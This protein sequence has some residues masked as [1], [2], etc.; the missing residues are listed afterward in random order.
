MNRLYLTIACCLFFMPLWGQLK[1][2]TDSVYRINEITVSSNRIE[3]YS[4]GNKIK[5][6]DS[7]LVGS[8]SA[9]S[10]AQVLGSFSQVQM[11]SYGLGLCNSSIR[12]AGSGHTAVIW[13]GFNL[14]DLLNGGADF[15]LIPINFI[16]DIKIQYGGG[17]AL[18][19]SGAIG[20]VVHLNNIINFDKGFSSS[21]KTG[22]GSY[23]NT[24]GGINISYSDEKY[25]VFVKSFYNKAKNNFT[26][27]N[28]QEVNA[29]VQSLKNA[30][31]EQYGLL[32]GNAFKLGRQSKI[33]S[34]FWFQ[35]NDKNIPPTMLTY[36]NPKKDNQKDVFYRATVSW[37]TWKKN[38]NFVLRSGF[39]NYFLVYDTSDYRSI[40][41][42]AEA[43]YNLKISRNHLVNTGIDYTYEKGISENLIS[44]AQR[45]RISL[46]ISYKFT[47]KENQ[48][49]IVT[50]FRNEIIDHT[51]TPFTFSLG[52]ERPLSNWI[53]LKG[54][55]SKN[56]RVP[57]FN[58]LYW[59][60]LGNP[61]LKCE[62]GFN[63]DVGTLLYK[64]F[65]KI[66]IRNE[67]TVFNNIVS[68]WILWYPHNDTKWRPENISLVRSRGLEND[69]SL[70]I[71]IG[72]ISSKT[73]ISYSFTRSIKMKADFANDPGLH[74][75]LI[76]VPLHK[77]LFAI[78]M[79]YNG[80]SLYYGQ[81]YTGIRYSETDNSRHINPYSIG[82]V[83]ISKKFHYRDKM[84]NISFQVN[85]LWNA[86]YQVMPYYPMPL[87]NYMLNVQLNIK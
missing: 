19:G 18:F 5:N 23:D 28:T 31:R 56:Y 33:E 14:Q 24:Y 36:H 71:P 43:E 53:L 67:V 16:D 73:S 35:D 66:D 78:T 11:N 45:N 34:F 87:R 32:A 64:K 72:A 25:A 30:E 21:L 4:V 2:I 59:I 10:L 75:Q 57:T 85:N 74:K 52:I 61:D 50:N 70:V 37:K 40:Q 76:Y 49:K 55:L 83:S 7:A 65:G 41:S 17:S 8:Y 22:Y 77:G 29:P 27:R 39:S 20:G 6:I 62:S 68:N 60:D 69:F 58:D 13:N 82:N 54:A 26:F 51:F 38:S 9:A 48:W 12:G 46:F 3:N 81:N 15:S 86:E 42:S 1:S 63:E 80:F 47:S 44:D 84:L 79:T